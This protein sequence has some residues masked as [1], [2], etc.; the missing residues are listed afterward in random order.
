MTEMP[1]QPSDL[2]RTA[3]TDPDQATPQTL[4]SAED[5]ATRLDAMAADIVREL[6]PDITMIPVLKG[7]FVFAA[8]LLR[9]LGRHGAKVRL[10]VQFLQ[11]ASYGA[12]KESSGTV[13]QTGTLPEVEGETVLVVE[14]VLDSGR[15]AA[16]A[17][18]LM[19]DAGARRAALAVLLDKPERRVVDCPADF[20]GFTIPDR[21]VVGYGIDWAE[22]FRELDHVAVV[23]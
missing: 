8:D 23:D 13:T 11:L 14:D 18:E 21:F 7:A 10:R 1:R 3:P 5:I 22:R 9:A 20:T 2:T 17:L 16:R 19:R 6:G 4:I 15:T 12:A